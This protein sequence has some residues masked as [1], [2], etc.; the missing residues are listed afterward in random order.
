MARSR[1]S[2]V[3]SSPGGEQLARL[4]VAERRRFAFAALC[5]RPLDAFDRIVGDG[6]FLAE[7]F[8]QRR[9]RRAR[10][11]PG[12]DVRPGHR[13]KFF[14]PDSTTAGTL[15]RSALTATPYEQILTPAS[16][17]LPGSPISLT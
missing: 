11:S 1:F 5:L 14:R 17:P 8:K 10:S 13:A 4:M 15:C 6:V 16:D 2:L 12:D 7:I 3:V 9:S